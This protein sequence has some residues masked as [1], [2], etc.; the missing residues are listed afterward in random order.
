MRDVCKYVLAGVAAF[1][2][3]QITSDIITQTG[4]AIEST[5]EWII[6]KGL[7]KEYEI[8]GTIGRYSS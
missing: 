3:Y 6:M 7:E 4:N 2:A 8:M 5:L 1:S